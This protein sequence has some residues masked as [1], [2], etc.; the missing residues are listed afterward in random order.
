MVLRRGNRRPGRDINSGHIV[1]GRG[2]LLAVAF[3][4]AREYS[5]FLVRSLAYGAGHV[6]CFGGIFVSARMFRGRRRCDRTVRGTSLGA[7]RWHCQSWQPTTHIRQQSR[8]VPPVARAAEE[9]G[10]R[11]RAEEAR[12]GAKEEKSSTSW[13]GLR[14]A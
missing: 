6:G 5:S 10:G 3:V 8:L 12:G 9:E 11:G 4:P 7:R 13:T 1:R 14:I 2:Q